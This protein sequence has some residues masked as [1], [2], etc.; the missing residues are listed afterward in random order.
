MADRIETLLSGSSMT[1]QEPSPGRYPFAD[2]ENSPTKR[3]SQPKSFGI[4]VV[5]D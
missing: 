5:G 3:A 1:V 2:M 4:A